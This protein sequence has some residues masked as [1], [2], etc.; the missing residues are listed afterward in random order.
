MPT[1]PARR[2]GSRATSSWLLRAFEVGSDEPL[3]SI[4]VSCFNVEP[5]VGECL[6]SALYQSYLNLEIVVV[7]DG[8]S[9]GTGDIIDRYSSADERVLTV[10]QP[11]RGLGAARN[12]GLDRA[13][14]EFIFFLDSDDLLPVDAIDRMVARA[15]ASG[16]DLVS[17]RMD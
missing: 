4:V 2:R 17:G 10:T 14:G 13:T 1:P 16:A 7:D 8:S 6:D 9:D 15:R 12:S 11:N 5:Y 3:V